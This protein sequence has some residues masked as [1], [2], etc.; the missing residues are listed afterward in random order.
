M[1]SALSHFSSPKNGLRNEMNSRT[2]IICD[3]FA[4]LVIVDTMFKFRISL[5]IIT[6]CYF[7]LLDY[8]V[9][10]SVFPINI[11]EKE[12]KWDF[13]SLWL[14]Q[15]V[16]LRLHQADTMFNDFHH[17]PEGMFYQALQSRCPTYYYMS[18]SCIRIQLVFHNDNNLSLLYYCKDFNFRHIRIFK[19][20]HGLFF[21]HSPVAR[22]VCP[23]DYGTTYD[24]SK[25]EFKTNYRTYLEIS[26]PLP[27]GSTRDKPKHRIRL[28]D[29]QVLREHIPFMISIYNMPIHRHNVHD[30]DCSVLVNQVYCVRYY[31]TLSRSIASFDAKRD[32]DAD[33]SI[34]PKMPF[35]KTSTLLAMSKTRANYGS[36]KGRPTVDLKSLFQKHEAE[37]KRRSAEKMAEELNV[38]KEATTPPVALP[39]PAASELPKKKGTDNVDNTFANFEDD[40]K[41]GE[42]EHSPY[43]DVLTFVIYGSSFFIIVVISTALYNWCYPSDRPVVQPRPVQPDILEMVERVDIEEIRQQNPRRS[44]RSA[45]RARRNQYANI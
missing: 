6:L 11:Q 7:L 34:F 36:L 44:N 23:S 17:I 24:I 35:I 40:I 9:I 1:D 16:D 18:Y 39:T 28:L 29:D 2:E 37:I 38:S 32:H 45:R 41:G 3:Q 15:F 31:T 8:R 20:E 21:Y 4:V 5:T 43:W 14:L 26:I 22:P 13:K 27:K 33:T 30:C 42:R 19:N 25:A 10:G 12:V